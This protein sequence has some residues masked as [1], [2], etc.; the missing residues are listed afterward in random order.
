MRLETVRQTLRGVLF[1]AP[2][3]ITCQE[4]DAFILDYVEGNL[5][6]KELRLFQLHLKV[7]RECREYLAAYEASIQAAQEGLSTEDDA[8]ALLHDVPEDLIAAVIASRSDPGKI[9]DSS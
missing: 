4:F 3:M 8:A 6:P 2:M 1:R 5:S 9:D 7:C